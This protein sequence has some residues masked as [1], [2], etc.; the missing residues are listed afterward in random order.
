MENFPMASDQSFAAIRR[1]FENTWI[2]TVL[3]VGYGGSRLARIRGRMR[4][5]PD[6]DAREE[7]ASV[8]KAD[9]IVNAN[10]RLPELLRRM[11]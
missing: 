1:E 8:M 7:R 6:Y 11:D 5:H 10:R 9:Q 4:R 2:D 3:A